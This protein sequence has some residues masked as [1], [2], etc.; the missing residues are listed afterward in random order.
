MSVEW[1]IQDTFIDYECALKIKSVCNKLNIES[2][3]ASCI[4][5]QDDIGEFDLK[6]DYIFYGSCN[7]I[8]RLDRLRKINNSN[9]FKNLWFSFW[10]SDARVWT[11]TFGT[12]MF[13]TVRENVTTLSKLVKELKSDHDY[14]HWFVKPVN[15]LKTFPGK[16]LNLQEAQE[17]V[18]VL[19]NR[20]VDLKTECFYATPNKT[21]EEWRFLVI[22]KKIIDYSTYNIDGQV[23]HIKKDLPSDVEKFAEIMANHW[24]PE[25][26]VMMD[27]AL[28]KNKNLKIMEFNCF[29]CSGLYCMNVE[30]VIKSVTEFAITQI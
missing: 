8:E 26:V 6:K 16:V 25:K 29:N 21:I 9:A 2:S 1:K 17:L 10:S 13:N 7:L 28:D 22:N 30:N 12:F 24:T 3:V 23:K 11:N 14:D 5:F 20:K 19:K 15:D 27:I 4:P 18:D